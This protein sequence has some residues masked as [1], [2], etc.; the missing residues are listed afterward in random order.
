M[1]F[2]SSHLVSQLSGMDKEEGDIRLK[3]QGEVVKAHSLIL[4]M[5]S[6][7]FEIAF[8]TSVGDAKSKTEINVEDCSLE[9]LNCAVNFMYG[10]PVPEDF[11]D[12]QGLLHQ[13][14]LFMMEDLKT[15]VGSLIAKT[16][17]LD[18]LSKIAPLAEK[19][20]EVTLQEI[21]G[22]FI[23]VHVE[24]L[25]EK[26][27]S[28]LALSMPSIAGKALHT[29]LDLKKGFASLARALRRCKSEFEEKDKSHR[30]ALARMESK[31]KIEIVK[32]KMECAKKIQE[33]K[34]KEKK[35]NGHI[36][37]IGSKILGIHMNRNQFKRQSDFPGIGSKAEYEA[38]VKGN[39]KANMLVR[40]CK[41]LLA[42]VST[43]K[44]RT[45]SVNGYGAHFVAV[46]EI[47]RII[48]PHMS[49]V[50]VK[51][52]NGVTTKQMDCFASL[53][54]LTDPVNT[55]FLA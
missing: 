51:W 31:S 27:I 13:A 11:A 41:G 48:N 22:D 43:A 32:A 36:Q 24:E 35:L 40:C 15:A 30:S 29:V 47:G 34:E 2:D 50:Q 9:V 55:S 26:V 37:D 16:L 21:C 4:S 42:T 5:R 52:Q 33:M 3:C 1:S 44:E 8:K 17:S 46:G 53:E 23:L 19:Y 14:D 28:E 20:G 38:Y 45:H 54:L 6:K 10:T 12:T 25:E 39:I 18:T 7:Y 49:G